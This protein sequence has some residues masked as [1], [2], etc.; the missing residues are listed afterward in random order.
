[1]R[2]SIVEGFQSGKLYGRGDL[3]VIGTR[4]PRPYEELRIILG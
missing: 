4:R 3:E 1:M 2:N